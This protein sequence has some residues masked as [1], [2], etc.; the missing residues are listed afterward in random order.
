MD[1][2]NNDGVFE[3][4]IYKVKSSLIL[5]LLTTHHHAHPP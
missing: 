2:G 3:Y 4:Y 5:Y 1:N